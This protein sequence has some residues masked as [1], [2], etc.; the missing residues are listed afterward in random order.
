VVRLRRDDIRRRP[1]PSLGLLVIGLALLFTGGRAPSAHAAGLALDKLATTNQSSA[2]RTIVSPAFSTVAANE[3]LVAFIS[4][5]GPTASGAQTFSG[6][7]GGGVTWTLRRRTN[8]QYGTSEIWTAVAPQ[9]LANQK[10]TATRLTGSYQGSITIAT[11]TGADTSATGATGTGNG[12]VGAP[13][14]SLTTTRAGSWVWGAGSDWDRAAARTVGGGQTKLAEYLAPAGDTFWVQRQT[15]PS[16]SA[17]TAVA[18]ND[19]APTNDRWNLSTIEILPAGVDTQAP[20]APTGLKSDSVSSTRVDL[21]WTASADDFGVAGYRVY[22]DGTQVGTATG[23]GYADTTV[24]PGTSY[25]YAVKAYDAA[26]HVS[27]SSNVLTLATPSPDT[28]AP[29]VAVSAPAAGATVSGAVTVRADATDDVGVAGVQF[30][31]DG[32]DL[33]GEDTSAPYVATWD[34]TAATN[35]SHTLTA[36]ARDTSGNP[37][38]SPDVAVTVNNNSNDPAQVG[39]WGPLIPLPAVSIH[40]ALTPTGKVL[41][42][43]G[44]FTQ[45]GSQY[46]FDPATGVASPLPD[47]VANLFCAAQAV[48]ADGRIDVAGGTNTSSLSGGI[49]GL[50][51]TTAYNW[52]TRDW[53]VLAPMRY[54]RWYAT[55]TTLADGK[56]LVTSGSNRTLTDI[57]PIPELYSPDTNTWKELTAASRSIPYYSFVYQ[58]PDGRI[59]RLGASEVPTPTE[60]LDLNTNQ[61]QTVDGR[62]LDGGSAANYAPGKFLK[63]GTASDGGF[64]GQSASTAYTLDM[65]QSG[66]SWQP[67]ASMSFKRSFLNLTN[68]PDGTVLATGGGTDKSSQIDANGVLPAEDWDP[69]TGN[70]TRYAAMAEPRLYHSVAT[71]LPDGRVY[72][73]GGGSDDGVTDHKTAQIFSPPYLFKGPRPTIASAPATVHWDAST[74]IGTPDAASISRVSLIR[75]GSV[76]HAF[77]QNARAMSLDFTQTVGGID[78][79]MPANGNL[80]PP[81]YYLLSIVNGQGVPSVASYVRFPAPYEDEQAP[82]A[83]SNLTATGQL[84]GASLSWTAATDDVGVVGYDIHRSTTAGF[85]PSAANNVGASTTTT[86]TD[87]GIPAG[88]YYYRVTA[89]DAAGNVGPASQEAH[90][91]AQT[92]NTAPSKPAGLNGTAASRSASLTWLASSD[93]V[94]VSG[95][96]VYR[97]GAAIATTATPGYADSGLTPGTTYSYTVAAY[98]AAGNLSDQSAPASLTTAAADSLALDKVVTTHQSSNATSI[99]SP[100]LSTTRPG[101][102]LVAFLASDGPASASGQSFSS[103]TGGGLTWRLRQRANTQAG[104]AEIWQAA[105]PAVVSN[106]VITATRANGT[107]QGSMA[108]ASFIGA[109][110]VTLGAVA[111]ANAATGV[112]RVSL[113]TTRANSWVWAVGI[114]WDKAVA[115]TLGA[116]QVLVDQYF[117]PSGDTYWMQRRDALTPSAGTPVTLDDISPTSDR[118]N[119]AAIE[120]LSG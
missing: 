64:T 24:A 83:P 105:A 106:A 34:T 12:A 118:W 101:E 93:D 9:A 3:L 102:L 41:L 75:T 91:T 96:R 65:N 25:A 74:F 73:A 86:Y 51:D 81:G 54:P 44:T 107:W 16:P 87:S 80:A 85:T 8:V 112:P 95:Y 104:T 15:D 58:L 59:I 32:R 28:L 20:T 38:T 77:D 72:V 110:T 56:V 84:G 99:S 43:Q 4:S 76:T 79:K 17:G 108:V 63:A 39:Q 47:A 30:L 57:V 40:S 115:R 111:A 36:R 6:V 66:P 98:D 23:T 60:T 69:S 67:T 97:D 21:S 120:I 33:G 48:L 29:S 94:G 113:T 90:A 37:A 68:L 114:D 18:L 46:E 31:L 2:A 26:G 117:S 62:L 10:V 88:E 50:P 27:D 103:V 55:A 42:F 35:G 119:V 92:D 71:L 22:R 78:V 116:G 82:G 5:D 7:T 45:G 100:S 89:R 1:A 109:D 11:F 19:T 49:L 52:K 70:W 53:S 14:A 61:W 13:T